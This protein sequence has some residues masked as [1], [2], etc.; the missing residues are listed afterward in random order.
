M[1]VGRNPWSVRQLLRYSV[2]PSGTRDT[3]EDILAGAKP[4]LRPVCISLWRKIAAL[5]QDFTEISGP[6][7]KI[8]SFGIGPRKM[9]EH[10]AYIAVYAAYVNLGFYH[11]AALA[12]RAG[13]LEGTRRRLRHISFRD[14]A[15]TIRSAVAALLRDAIADR[16]RNARAAKFLRRS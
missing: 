6:R 10:Y 5:H 15:S 11:G 16:R 7:Q 9:S 2:T 8:A 4:A 14:A 12:D 1:C 13:L 3:F